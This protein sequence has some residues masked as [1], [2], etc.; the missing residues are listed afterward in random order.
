VRL[1]HP[2]VIGRC[3]SLYLA[4]LDFADAYLVARAEDLGDSWVLSFDRFDAKLQ[5]TTNVRRLE[6]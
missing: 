6:P 5:G 2:T 3:L 4:G 1:E